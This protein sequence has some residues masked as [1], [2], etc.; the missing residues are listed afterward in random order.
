VAA[1]FDWN[2]TATKVNEYEDAAGHWELSSADGPSGSVIVADGGLSKGFDAN[3]Y[4][5]DLEM[6][7]QGVLDYQGPVCVGDFVAGHPAL[8]D[9]VVVHNGGFGNFTFAAP[10]DTEWLQLHLDVPGRT[11]DDWT[12]C[13]GSI[14][15]GGVA[16][17]DYEPRL[18]AVADHFLEELGW[19]PDQ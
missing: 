8:S 13:E 16:S 2:G 19:R 3:P 10:P 1:E 12:S 4:N 7:R 6:E 9:G 17:E 15:T 11:D 5:I 18:F 14:T